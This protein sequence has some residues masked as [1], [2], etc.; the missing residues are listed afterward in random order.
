MKVLLSI[1]PEF[2]DKIFEGTKLFEFRRLIFKNPEIKIVIVYA[3]SP[4]QKV[5]GE[6]EIENIFSLEP[7]ELWERTKE[8]SG[9]SEKFFF[10]YFAQCKI[11]HAIKIK[12]TK[13]YKKPLNLKENFNVTPPQS[14]L[15]LT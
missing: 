10:E 14:Y 1:K 3:S 2:A 12:K 13:K 8:Y 5:V 9:I 4:I 15:Y 6:F 11:A 7:T